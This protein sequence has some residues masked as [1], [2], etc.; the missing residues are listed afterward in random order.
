MDPSSGTDVVGDLAVVD[1]ML[2]A[3]VPGLRRVNGRGLVV[4]PGLCDLRAGL[5]PD[6][7]PAR[8]T[9]DLARAAAKGGYSGICIGSSPELFLDDPAVVAQLVA[10]G[11][12]SGVRV[13]VVGAMTRGA[14]G[15]GLADLGALAEAGVVGVGDG[16]TRSTALTRAALLYLGPLG[17]RLVVRAE[18]PSLA[19][20]ALV[21]TGAVSTRLGLAGWP[22]SAEITTVER[23]LAL[24]AETGGRIHFSRISTAVAV[25]A[26]RRARERGVYV[27]CDV[28]AAH[29]ALWDGWIAGARRFAWETPDDA[30]PFDAPLDPALAY[31]AACR[32]DPPLPSRADARALLAAVADGTIDAIVSDHAPLPAQRKLVEFAAAAP[33]MIGLPMALSLGLAAVEAGVIP[34]LR[35]VAALSSRPAELIGEHRTLAPGTPADLVVFDPAARWRVEREALASVHDN[36]PLLGRELPG[37]VRLTLFDGRV[38]YGDVVAA[39]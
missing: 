16:A 30:S 31:D 33:G 11:T 34:L 35:L 10:E 12:T 23:D 36:T 4:A 2:A 25:E 24:A 14:A 1:G 20:G 19:A 38:T 9:A 3:A 27:T 18:D 15:D 13:G 26:I 6:L 22:P 37:V 5:A 39:S 29:L 32:T 17:L 28:A 8:A 7:E 21:H